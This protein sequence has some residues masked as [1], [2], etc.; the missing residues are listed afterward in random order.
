MI[1]PAALLL[2]ALAACGEE[3]RDAVPN[4]TL[5]L[6]GATMGTFWNAAVV[7]GPEREEQ[8]LAL[9]AN[10][11][12]KTDRLMSTWKEESDVSRF[13]RALVDEKITLDS[14]TGQ[15]LQ[16][17]LEIAAA[18]QGAFDPTVAP[19]VRAWGFGAGAAA[20]PNPP[21]ATELALLRKRTGWQHLLLE[22]AEEGVFLLA[23]RVPGL[24]LD[25]SAIAKGFGTDRAADALTAAGFADFLLEVGGEIVVRGKRADG[26]AWVL[27]LEQPQ[28]ALGFG[29]QLHRRISLPADGALA[30]SGDYRQFRMENGR[31]ISHELDPRTGQPVNNGVAVV[32]ATALDCATADAWATALM[33]LGGPAGLALAQSTPTLEV[34]FL[35][36]EESGDFSALASASFPPPL[37]QDSVSKR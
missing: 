15:C 11:L 9:I 36:R 25:L 1:R 37:P 2:V 32:T 7:A 31:R 34:Q 4:H 33:V 35:I 8:A 30:T 18:S 24:E 12:A 6:A 27:G 23:K 13:S 16:L 21:T 28:D 14:W 10:A 29:S 20:A 5:R 26:Q 3:R 17:A 22:Q 19:L